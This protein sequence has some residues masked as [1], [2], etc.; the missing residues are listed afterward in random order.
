MFMIPASPFMSPFIP[1]YIEV[2]YED[3]IFSKYFPYLFPCHAG[4]TITV[5][6]DIFLF[7]KLLKWKNNSLNLF[8]C[9]MIFVSV[10]WYIQGTTNMSL[11]VFFSTPKIHESECDFASINP[12]PEAVRTY[13]NS[14][15]SFI[16]VP[17]NYVSIHIWKWKSYFFN[18]PTPLSLGRLDSLQILLHLQALFSPVRCDLFLGRHCRLGLGRFLTS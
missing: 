6:Y 9:I 7:W 12:F 4:A 5:Y 13:E 16:E 8:V 2:F 18:L 15:L 10:C 17:D 14:I 11:F 3:I 1:S